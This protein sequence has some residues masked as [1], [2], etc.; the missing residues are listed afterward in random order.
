MLNSIRSWLLASYLCVIGFCLA[1]IVVT[2]V[3]FLVR[4]NPLERTLILQRLT[5][6][7]GVVT[8][9]GRLDTLADLPPD[10]I[11]NDVTTQLGSPENTRVLL[12]D[13]NGRI[14]ADSGK[15]LVGR[16]LRSMSRPVGGT[17]A[18]AG[19]QGEIPRLDG[20]TWLY[21]ARPV[22]VGQPGLTLVLAAS[23]SDNVLRASITR[24][25]V[26]MMIIA[27]LA[28]LVLSLLL[29]W[30]IARSIAQPVQRVAQA[31]DQI[32]DGDYSAKVPVGGPAEMRELAA[33]FND[34]ASQVQNVQQAQR[35][36]LANVSHDL[37]TPLTSIQGFA[38]AIVD[39][40]ASD[41]DVVR[42]SAGVIRDEA[43]RMTRM[44]TEL[45]DIAR[46]ESGQIVMQREPVRVSDIVKSCV[47]R[48]A[49]R[50]QQARVTMDVQAP[51]DMPPVTGDGDRL[52]QVFTNLLDNALRHS[53]PGG[54]VSVA[55]RN[56]TGSSIV[57]RGKTWPA[58]VEVSVTD[59]GG[60]I[61]A[62]DL[63]RVFE[64]FYQVDKSRRRDN[65]SLGLGLFI[66]K[67]I[68]EAHG[69]TVKAESVVGL[70]TRFVV[71]LP[72]AS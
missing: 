39:G 47:E 9:V 64:R 21:I 49:L 10:Q 59:N 42:R 54:K 56:M 46:I 69:G 70:G 55:A 14:V 65:D 24:G 66:V 44:V 8:R 67:Q 25:F 41:P 57:R 68:I 58:G 1:V 15:S 32:A 7:M 27:G 30:L 48:L 11:L 72:A 51:D 20:S 52:A 38:Q 50:A 36:F 35:D 31:A 16:N 53:P 3:V 40:A 34:M 62:E 33:N 22:R 5:I 37:K 19:T 71:T 12:V 23:L 28:G 13:P 17:G 2:L 63:S 29:A 6:E 18:N 43:D 4:A 45:L 60:G 61:P 26:G